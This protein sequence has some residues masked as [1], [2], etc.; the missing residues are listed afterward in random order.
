VVIQACQTSR[1]EA[2]QSRPH[3]EGRQ[4]ESLRHGWNTVPLVSQKDDAGAF[5]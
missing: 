1:V 5:D 4:L 2:L 3:G